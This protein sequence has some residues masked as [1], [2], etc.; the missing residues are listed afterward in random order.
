MASVI[1]LRGEFVK[2]QNDFELARGIF[3]DLWAAN[4]GLAKTLAA[5]CKASGQFCEKAKSQLAFCKTLKDKNMTQINQIT[6][7]LEEELVMR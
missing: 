2:A 1:C 6:E 4:I 7:Q 5:Q 3:P